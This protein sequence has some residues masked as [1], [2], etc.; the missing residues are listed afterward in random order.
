MGNSPVI[1]PS[2]EED[3]I[4]PLKKNKVTPYYQ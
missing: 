3:N 4:L 1:T 2:Q